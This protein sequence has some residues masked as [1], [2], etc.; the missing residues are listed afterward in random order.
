M[1][2][3]SGVIY[4]I[5]LLANGYNFRPD[6]SKCNITG[7]KQKYKSVYFLDLTIKIIALNE[8]VTG[9]NHRILKVNISVYSILIADKRN[10]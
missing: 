5:N 6:K 8:M 10:R 2:T 3:T 7:I 4:R 9:I 1:S